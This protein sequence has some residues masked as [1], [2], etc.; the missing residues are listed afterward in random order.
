MN[1]NARFREL[2]R[3]GC[4][5]MPNP[6][7]VGSARILVALGARALATTSSGHAASLGRLDQR[8]TLDELLGH[9][10]LLSSAVDVP[11]SVDAERGFAADPAGVAET[12]RLLAEA[13]AAG[14]SIEDYNLQAGVIDDAGAAAERVAAAAE[15][16][17][18]TGLVLTA[19][20]DQHLYTAPPL[21]DTVARLRRYQ[22]A[23][24]DVVYA[25]GL[26]SLHDI[27]RVVA[28]VEAP[29]NVLALPGGPTVAEL[30]ATGVRRV[31][32]GGALAF[33]AYGALARAAREL[34]GQGTYGFTDG[35]LSKADSAAAFER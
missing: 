11:L 20:A 29:L 9:V 24:A 3:E 21:E 19:R 26:T 27:Q 12:V 16:A 28:E 22:Q 4:L 34:L 10:R 1:A 23:G 14:C 17:R 5:V 33:V 8:V 2:H 6:W 32:I 25:P 31:S 18:A 15:A 30:A 13:G 7:D 35:A